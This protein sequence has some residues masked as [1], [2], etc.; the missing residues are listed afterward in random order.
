MRLNP[1]RRNSPSGDTDQEDDL[2]FGEKVSGEGIKLVN[3][4]GNFN[5]QRTGLNEYFAYQWLIE[6]PWWKFF[7]SVLG[8]YIVINFVLGL[9]FYLLGPS[10]ISGL[11]QDTWYLTLLECFFFSV[12]TFTTVGYGTMAPIDLPHQLLAALGAL[13]GLMSLALATGLLFARFSR[14]SRLLVFSENALIA[15]YSEGLSFQFRLANRSSTKLINVSAQIVYSWI[16]EKDGK[17]KRHFNNLELERTE[18]AML[19]LNW[20]VVHPIDSSSPLTGLTVDEIQATDGEF[21]VQLSAFDETYGRQIFEHT[22]YYAHCL[23]WNHSFEPMY[24]PSE[25]GTMMLHLDRIDLTSSK[26]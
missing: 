17:R 26:S 10:G 9:F 25:N 3:K 7:A 8:Y 19:P 23:K 4:D 14:P 13:V 22:S 12:Q 16:T 1:F 21:I 11:S 2:G 18:I 24:Q 20:T 5:V 6:M 15:P